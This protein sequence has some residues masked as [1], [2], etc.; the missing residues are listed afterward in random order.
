MELLDIYDID[1]NKTGKTIERGNK[2]FQDGEYIKLATVWL[3]SQGKYLIQKCSAERDSEYAVT[4]G[5]VTSGNTPLQQAAIEV[6]EELNLDI[7][8][9]SLIYLGNIIRGHAMFEVFLYQDDKII[10]HPFT[11]QQEEVEDILWLDSL[12]INNLKNNGLRPS[13]LQQFEKYI[14]DKDI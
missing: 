5:H 14:K 11:L 13:T 3:K 7:D 10:N 6:K 4:G 9:N 12:E 2:N 8:E 1:G